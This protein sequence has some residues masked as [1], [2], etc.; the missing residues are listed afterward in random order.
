MLLKYVI[1]C[2]LFIRKAHVIEQSLMWQ[3]GIWLVEY[4]QAGEKLQV[5]YKESACDGAKSN[6]KKWNLIG[7]IQFKHVKSWTLD[8]VFKVRDAT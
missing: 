6:V 8:V 7:R 3:N 5:A 4:K 2:K 1:E